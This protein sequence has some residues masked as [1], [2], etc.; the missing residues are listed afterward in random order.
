MKEFFDNI[1]GKKFADCLDFVL[2]TQRLRGIRIEVSIEKPKSHREQFKSLSS[3]F[4][5]KGYETLGYFEVDTPRDLDV[6][7]FGRKVLHLGVYFQG[8]V[9]HFCGGRVCR[10]DVRRLTN[11]RYYRWRN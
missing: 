2:A 11:L 6:V 8:K 5:N 9:Y 1:V 4:K 10:K 3:F 7:T